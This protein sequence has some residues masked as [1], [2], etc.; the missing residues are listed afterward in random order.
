MRIDVR[1]EGALVV[2]EL[3]G[4]V[5]IGEPTN[6]LRG[7][8][9]ELLEA[10]GRRFVFDMRGVPW[11]DS[12]GLGEVFACHKRAREKGGA[13]KLVLTGKPCSLFTITQLDRI[14]EIFP[15]PQAAL[16]SCADEPAGD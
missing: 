3:H 4:E 11:L 15:D 1:Q 16:A 2:L 13:V 14:L 8:F 7:R 10:G 9:K 5:R 12:S 6:L